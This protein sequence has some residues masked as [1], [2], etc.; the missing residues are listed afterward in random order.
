MWLIME[1]DSVKL[2]VFHPTATFTE[3]GT[4][5][6][7]WDTEL[8][9][10]GPRLPYF[11]TLCGEKKKYTKAVGGDTPYIGWLDKVNNDRIDF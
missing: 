8:T 9:M 7:V 2:R 10:L 5:I 6:P 11:L 4:L 1:D 3:V